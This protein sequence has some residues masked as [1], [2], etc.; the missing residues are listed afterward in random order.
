MSLF[1]QLLST[2]TDS[3]REVIRELP[4]RGKQQAILQLY[5]STNNPD[6]AAEHSVAKL[7]MSDSHLHAT[8][9][10]LL[11]RCY[12]ALIPE[13]GFE[14]LVFLQ[15]RGL[16]THFKREFQAQERYMRQIAKDKEHLQEFY[17]RTLH[18]LIGVTSTSFDVKLF[19][20]IMAMCRRSSTMN[21]HET[22]V[23]FHV[24]KLLRDVVDHAVNPVRKKP[25]EYKEQLFKR[26]AE[27]EQ[28]LAEEDA[29]IARYHLTYAF[30]LYYAI[31]SFDAKKFRVY[32]RLLEEDLLKLPLIIRED[33]QPKVQLRKGSLAFF[34]DDFE[35]AYKIYNTELRSFGMDIYQRFRFHLDVFV[36][37]ALGLGKVD[38][39]RR[40]LNEGIAP[41]QPAK[42]TP[43]ATSEAIYRVELALLD[44]RYTVAREFLEQGFRFNA[45]SN[46]ILSFDVQLRLLEWVLFAL[47]GA[48]TKALEARLSKDAKHFYRKG[49]RQTDGQLMVFST[50]KNFLHGSPKAE[51]PQLLQ[52]QLP[53]QPA[54]Q[55]LLIEA[56]K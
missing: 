54:L 56:L 2:L 5:L 34:E 50:L 10:I 47:D 11:Q 13:R 51:L 26:L 46:Y 24:C 45:G 17:L 9:S 44:T 37:V 41:I 4:L 53:G 16:D 22:A 35:G 27:T 8:L 15:T 18:L 38:I 43:L 40:L 42:R 55:G 31:F 49:L 3:E 20:A 52:Q 25:S 39:A 19:T 14:L 36:R 33:E 1:A 21:E 6:S 12:D 7:G 29:P 32:L 28:L 23:Q 48:T 30:L